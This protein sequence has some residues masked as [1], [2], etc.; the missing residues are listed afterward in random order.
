MEKSIL[1]YLEKSEHQF[2]DKIAFSDNKYEL[3]YHELANEARSIGSF[4]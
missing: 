3:T 2:P 4:F 1:S